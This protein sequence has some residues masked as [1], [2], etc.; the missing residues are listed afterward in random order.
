MFGQYRGG[1]HIMTLQTLQKALFTPRPSTSAL[2]R[3]PVELRFMAMGELSQPPSGDAYG[4]SLG[5][6]RTKDGRL[7]IESF[8]WFM[9]WTRLRGVC[10]QLKLEVDAHICGWVRTRDISVHAWDLAGTLD[11]PIP[12]FAHVTRLT[13]L[14]DVLDIDKGDTY[15]EPEV[16]S[17]P[18]WKNYKKALH[19]LAL[20]S[21]LTALTIRW[22]A[23]LNDAINDDTMYDLRSVLIPDVYLTLY[24]CSPTDMQCLETIT[25]VGFEDPENA[26]YDEL[27]DMVKAEEKMR[28]LKVFYI[29]R[30][31]MEYVV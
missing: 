17:L 1:L 8:A 9:Y 28:A 19:F 4:N 16:I 10:R 5:T 21:R 2:M 15:Q 14:F 27:C 25:S 6:T 24:N 31:T 11:V 30:R 23:D 12:L 20:M 13:V 3:L 29:G 7:S 22:R 26:I 18:L